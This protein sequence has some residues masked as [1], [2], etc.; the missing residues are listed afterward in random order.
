MQF[1]LDRF[2]RLAMEDSAVRRNEELRSLHHFCRTAMAA[3]SEISK[4]LPKNWSPRDFGTAVRLTM[5]LEE[6][7]TRQMGNSPSSFKDAKETLELWK[8][9]GYLDNI[10][11]AAKKVGFLW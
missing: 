9:S 6:G 5:S 2:T 8:A 1:L 4:K 3:N 10:P 11:A 7:R